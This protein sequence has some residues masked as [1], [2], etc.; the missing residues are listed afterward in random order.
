MNSENKEKERKKKKIGTPDSKNTRGSAA[1]KAT[2]LP[3]AW[4]CGVWGSERQEARGCDEAAAA[5]SPQQQDTSPQA[6][7]VIN[8]IKIS[9]FDWFFFWGGVRKGGLVEME[10]LNTLSA[11]LPAQ[12]DHQAPQD[13]L[14]ATPQM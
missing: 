3:C 11:P 6:A 7:N 13:G 10:P 12:A 5:A 14:P 2:L 4:P 8:P 9:L 1:A